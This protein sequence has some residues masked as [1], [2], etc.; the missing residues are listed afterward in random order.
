MNFLTLVAFLAVII[1]SSLSFRVESIGDNFDDDRIVGGNTARPGQFRHMVSLR[2]REHHN[3]K[4]FWIHDCGGAILNTRWILSVAHCTF[5][6]NPS[7]TVVVIGAH[8]IQNDGTIYKLDRVVNHPRYNNFNYT[9]DISL[10]QTNERIHFG[11]SSK[12][13]N[14]DKQF[15]GA[16]VAATVS[17]WGWTKVWKK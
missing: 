14:L 11:D 17:G 6:S 3:G 8:H 13:I 15:I 16:D 12:R 2:S 9:Y 4:D 7:N 5:N 1:A 10:L